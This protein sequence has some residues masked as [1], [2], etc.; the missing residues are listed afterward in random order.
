MSETFAFKAALR[1]VFS[2][3]CELG[4]VDRAVYAALAVRVDSRGEYAPSIDDP[5]PK[6]ELCKAACVSR[7]TLTRSLA[8]LR[9]AGYVEIEQRR[10]SDGGNAPS[11]Y[12]LPPVGQ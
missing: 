10:A 6:E 7:R 9:E 3:E 4:T 2:P 1:H 11:A 8:F 5:S 12:R